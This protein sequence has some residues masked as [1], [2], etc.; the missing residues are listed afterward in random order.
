MLLFVGL[1]NPGPQYAGNR[2]NVG[3]MAL[4][5]IHRD[6]SF[7][8]W[9]KKFQGE[10]SEGRIDGGK[11]LLLKPQTFM[12]ESGRSVLAAAS[13]YKI[14]PAG[15]V[16]FHD[17]LDL[18]PGKV[19]V[20]TGGGHGGHNG[21]RSI[22]AHL[23]KDY[24]RVRI[25]IGHPGDKDRVSPYVLSDFAKADATWLDPLIEAMAR[26]ASLLAKGEDARF[27]NRLAQ[28]TGSDEPASARGAAKPKGQSHIRQA[29]PK[30]GTGSGTGAVP[31]GEPL[32]AMLGKL[33]GNK[34]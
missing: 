6:P 18:P 9:S 16:V 21:L 22:D 27:M 17:E 32:A 28:T 10:I 2:H 11:V 23:G 33:F 15:I 25:G 24:R 20:K 13:F 31:P 8:P 7:S 30:I 5:E 29:R 1:G 3:F 34:D 19:R 12:N 4:D 26:D 14:A